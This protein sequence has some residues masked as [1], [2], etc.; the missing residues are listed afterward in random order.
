[1]REEV[2]WILF[3]KMNSNLIQVNPLAFASDFKRTVQFWAFYFVLSH[4]KVTS[5]ENY[6]YYLFCVQVGVV[7][8]VCDTWD[9]MGQL[10]TQARMK[11]TF[12]GQCT[13]IDTHEY[14]AI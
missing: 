12:Y 5:W 3:N 1:M 9:G 2:H 7:W 6:Y 13:I 14:E 11:P 4:M 8:P 10:V